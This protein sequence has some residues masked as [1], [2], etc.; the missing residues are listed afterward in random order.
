[1]RNQTRRVDKLM[2][3]YI[4]DP[5][6]PVCLWFSYDDGRPPVNKPTDEEVDAIEAA[7]GT[8]IHISFVSPKPESSPI[9]SPTNSDLILPAAHTPW[10]S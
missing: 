3:Q 6:G 5:L 2:K 7:G 1:M 8:V 10:R 4:P 9:I